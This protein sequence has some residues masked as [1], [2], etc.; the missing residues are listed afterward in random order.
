MG[1]T[2]FTVLSASRL[3]RT[4]L[5]FA[6]SF[7]PILILLRSA[8]LGEEEGGAGI[9]ERKALGFSSICKCFVFRRR[10][11]K[12]RRRRGKNPP[13]GSSLF[14]RLTRSLFLC[15]SH[16]L[17]GKRIPFSYYY[18]AVGAKKCSRL[19]KMNCVCINF[20]VGGP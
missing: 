19:Q 14:L 10:G 18:Y 16:S 20:V 17:C 15:D 2:H 6:A 12:R 5:F 8:S 3:K 13:P 9:V 11:G 4:L 7:A 1:A